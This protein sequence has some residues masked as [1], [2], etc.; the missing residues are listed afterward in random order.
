MKE[1]SRLK[2]RMGF[3]RRR[4]CCIVLVV[5]DDA[6]CSGYALMLKNESQSV[7]WVSGVAWVLMGPNYSELLCVILER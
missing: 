4:E 1:I 6:E 7:T 2:S 3:H 5:K